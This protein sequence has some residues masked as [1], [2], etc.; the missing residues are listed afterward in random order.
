MTKLPVTET[1][2]AAYRFAFA[3]VERVIGLIWLPIV[4]LTVADYFAQGYYYSAVAAADGPND[5]A[6]IGP[7]TVAMIGVGILEVIMQ[8]VVA[9]AIA[10]EIL[11]PLDRPLFLRFSLGGTE[12]RVVGAMFGI[13]ALLAVAVL[14]C[15]IA[16]GIVGTVAGM[17]LHQSGAALKSVIFGCVGL[18]ALI[19]L[20][21]LIY[22]LVR[23][24]SLVVPAAAVDG[25]FGME[26]SWKLLKGNVGRMLL[27]SLGAGLPMLLVYFG[28]QAVILGPEYLH[29]QM[30][31]PTS[32]DVQFARQVETMRLMAAHLPMLKGLDFIIA[33]FLYGLGYAA[34]AFAFKAL[35]GR[36]P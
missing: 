7:A 21:F 16:G 2:A 32:Q 19:G 22:G 24:G 1:I 27:I 20:P 5:I 8:A 15:V 14:V 9:V 28:L 4:V 31:L 29:L 34:P 25:G 35:S 36:T 13:G 23:L 3:G 6:R 11:A 17:A 10:R 30:S 33:P 26:R 12:L 18:F